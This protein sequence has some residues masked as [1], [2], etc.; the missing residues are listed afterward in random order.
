[1]THTSRC[2]LNA[3]DIEHRGPEVANVQHRVAPTDAAPAALSAG[4]AAEGLVRF[5]VVGRV[6]HDDVA[7]LQVVD[8][9]ERTFEARRVDGSLK[10]EV[11]VVRNRERLFV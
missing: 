8:K 4:R 7:D 2:L 10:P 9:A 3:S 1:M 6:V 5:P 11:R